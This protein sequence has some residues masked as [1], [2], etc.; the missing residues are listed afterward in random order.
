MEV[1][2]SDDVRLWESRAQSSCSRPR[3]RRVQIGGMM[4]DR[5]RGG[6]G[7]QV[8]GGSKI[9]YDVPKRGGVVP[10]C[11]THFGLRGGDQ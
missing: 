5:P 3:W 9:D 6:A 11:I 8:N 10:G 7:S 2:G 4:S 1:V